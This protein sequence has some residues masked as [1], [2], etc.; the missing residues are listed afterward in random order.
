MASRGQ[1]F[2]FLGGFAQTWTLAATICSSDKRA[3]GKD[4]VL[5]ASERARKKGVT[6][7][8]LVHGSCNCRPAAMA[9]SMSYQAKR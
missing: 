7:P 1:S 8:T 3:K 5:V 6:G 4:Q 9:L 2:D